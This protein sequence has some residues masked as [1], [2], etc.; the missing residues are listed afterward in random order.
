M[1]PTYRAGPS[2]SRPAGEPLDWAWID[3]PARIRKAVPSV[4]RSAA[5]PGKGVVASKTKA[6]AAIAARP[7]QPIAAAIALR[8]PH[9]PE[10]RQRR[11]QRQLP[12]AAEGREV[13]GGRLV[14]GELD[15]KREGADQ[16]DSERHPERRADGAAAA[17]P[18]PG[19]GEQQGRPDQ[20]EL[21]LDRQR[22]EVEHRARFDVLGEVVDRLLGEVPVGRVEGGADDVAGDFDRAHGRE[23]QQREDADRGEQ[24]RRERQQP[25]G[26]AGVEAA[27]GDAPGAVDLV[28][29]KAGDEEAGDDEEDVDADVAAGEERDAGVAE[30][31]RADR[32]R[33]HALDVRPEAALGVTRPCGNGLGHGNRR[34]PSG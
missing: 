2:E 13:G 7:A 23:Q 19:D 30:Q 18:E 26:A 14:A 3:D 9:R 6:A 8:D 33:A 21:L 11:S 10:Q 17:A 4:G 15:P 24:D 1:R 27:Q 31:D 34:I 16:E 22:P 25:P 32:D 20:V 29:Q 12:D 5:T 28:E